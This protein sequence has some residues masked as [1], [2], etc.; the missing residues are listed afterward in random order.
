M[1]DVALPSKYE[2]DAYL[3]KLEFIRKHTL[4]FVTHY[5]APFFL[6]EI[7]RALK[8]PHLYPFV[9]YLLNQW[10]GYKLSLDSASL[11]MFQHVFKY[12]FFH[13]N[14]ATHNFFN[15][16]T[17][18]QFLFEDLFYIQSYYKMPVL[19]CSSRHHLCLQKLRHI[20]KPNLAHF[21][22][23]SFPVSHTLRRTTRDALEVTGEEL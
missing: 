1:G 6:K 14:H 9:F 20:P 11:Q 23:E 13:A 12:Y 18:I 4:A 15:Y 5:Q 17:F 3:V 8:H 19:K 22:Y 21:S 7:M 2:K 16:F 10:G